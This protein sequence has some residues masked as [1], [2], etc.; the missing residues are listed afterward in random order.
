M[1]DKLCNWCDSSD[2]KKVI[3]VA[4]L[5]GGLHLMLTDSQDVF[6]MLALPSW[7]WVSAQ[8]IVGL[9]LTVGGVCCLKNC[10]K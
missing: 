1:F 9:V 2:G 8:H 7:G 4:V 6:G 5:V 10:W 3:S